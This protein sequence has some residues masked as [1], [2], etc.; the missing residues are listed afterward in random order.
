[1]TP[2]KARNQKLPSITREVNTPCG[3]CYV[4]VTFGADDDW[5]EE[6][7]LRMKKQGTC[8]MASTE[9]VGKLASLALRSGADPRDVF[10][11]LKG[12]NCGRTAFDEG[13]MLCSCWDAIALA[14]REAWETYTADSNQMPLFPDPAP[15]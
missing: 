10:K 3:N 1:M 2:K 5:P 11:Y 12:I 9:A 6:L 8:Q 13:E 15:E 4:T 7:F 14:Y